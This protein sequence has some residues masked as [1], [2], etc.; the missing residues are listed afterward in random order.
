MVTTTVLNTKTKEVDNKILG[1]SGLVKK[2][3]N[4]AKISEIEGKYF[5]ASDYNKFTGDILNAKIKQKE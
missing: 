3:D 5:T 1:L 4:D 2:I